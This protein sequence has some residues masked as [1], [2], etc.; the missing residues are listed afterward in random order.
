MDTDILFKIV[1]SVIVVA[2]IVISRYL[3][4][5]IRANLGNE[6][7][8]RVVQ[9]ISVLVTAVQQM[10]P[11]Y[12]GEQKLEFVT[13]KITE[14]LNK[15]HINFT[16]EQVRLLIESAVKQMKIEGGQPA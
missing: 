6:K 10:F 13:E 12:T 2:I 11:Q 4:P 7:F 16:E 15:Q 8:D 5:W 1:E 9:E 14:F 3:V